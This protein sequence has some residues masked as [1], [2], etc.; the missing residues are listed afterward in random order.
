MALISVIVPVYNT[1][2]YLNACLESVVGQTYRELEIILVDDGSTDGSGELCDEWAKK[3]SRIQVIHLPENKGVSNA[4]NVGIKASHG[5]Y[6]YMMDGDDFIHPQMLE[7]LF[8]ALDGTIYDFS[9]VRGIKAPKDTDINVFD[10]H[11]TDFSHLNEK[12]LN[13]RELIASLYGHCWLQFV[14]V[15]NKLYRREL[16]DDVKFLPTA[17]QDSNWNIRVALKAKKV[18]VIDAELYAWRQHEA[19]ITHQGVDFRVVDRINSY[20]LSYQTIAETKPEYKSYALNGLYHVIFYTKYN[21][22]GTAFHDLS[23]QFAANAH[24]EASDELLHCRE[25]PCWR[26]LKIWIFYYCPSLFR[27]YMA[28]LKKFFWH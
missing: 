27:L 22:K 20:L 28:I 12:E 10:T 5:D 7:L 19:S 3:D 8:N 13:Q 16:I 1:K 9:M 2:P 14:V 15:W 23:K 18:V 21:T 11:N 25:L 17:S 26:K 6:V 4:R 24:K